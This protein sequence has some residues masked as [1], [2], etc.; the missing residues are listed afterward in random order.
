MHHHDY[1]HGDTRP[2]NIL[3]VGEMKLSDPTN[4]IMFKSMSFL[5]KQQ[6]TTSSNTGHVC[7]CN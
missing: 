5:G 4:N 6:Q 1:V 3:V 2:Q 7:A